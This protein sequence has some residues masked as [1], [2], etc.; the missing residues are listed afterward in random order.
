MSFQYANFPPSASHP[1]LSPSGSVT[2]GAKAVC[3]VWRKPPALD[4]F[5]AP[6]MYRAIPVRSF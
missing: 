1:K 2:F 3:D 4:V 5:N 6:F